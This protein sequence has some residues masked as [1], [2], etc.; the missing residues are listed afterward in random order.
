MGWYVAYLISEWGCISDVS[1]IEANITYVKDFDDFDFPNVISS[2]SDGTND[3]L[4]LKTYF[5]TCDEFT[6]QI[7]NRWGNLVW[8]QSQNTTF[9]EGKDLG[10]KDLL[11]G[12]YFW[13]LNFEQC[14]KSG[15]IHIVR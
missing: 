13:K 2:N 12:I 5:E 10:G 9:F 11:E 14:E 1:E 15:F 7:F 4:D 8:E 6:L 3:F